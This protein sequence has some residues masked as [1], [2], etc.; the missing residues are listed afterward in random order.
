MGRDLRARG[1][2]DFHYRHRVFHSKFESV[3]DSELIQTW[4]I[5]LNALAWPVAILLIAYF[6]RGI[7]LPTAKRGGAFRLKV[8]DVAKIVVE[9]A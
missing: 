1:I 7:I 5:V 4:T 6:L 3:M 9:P 2:K 8:K